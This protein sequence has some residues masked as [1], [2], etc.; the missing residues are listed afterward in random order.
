MKRRDL[1]HFQDETPQ[2]NRES[3]EQLIVCVRRESYNQFSCQCQ[4]V[5]ERYSNC[6]FLSESHR[7]LLGK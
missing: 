7:D 3:N 2:L 5:D 4:G 1:L 6:C